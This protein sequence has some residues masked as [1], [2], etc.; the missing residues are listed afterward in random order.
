MGRIQG[1]VS[2]LSAHQGHM[3]SVNLFGDVIPNYLVMVVSAGFLH[4]KVIIFSFIITNYLE[5][6]ILRLHKY[7]AAL[8]I[9][10]FDIHWRIFS[11]TIVTYY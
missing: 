1:K 6:D 7:S 5:G 8:L 9:T 2:L 11:T 3:R 10:N 4:C